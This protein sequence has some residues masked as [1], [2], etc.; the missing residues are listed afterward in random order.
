MSEIR[1]EWAAKA[2]DNLDTCSA[3]A[4]EIEQD[5]QMLPTTEVYTHDATLPF[6]T[7]QKS[8]AVGRTNL[9]PESDEKHDGAGACVPEDVDV[10]VMNPPWGKRI[11]NLSLE[12]SEEGAIVRSLLSQFVRKSHY[13]DHANDT[14]TYQHT[15]IDTGC[16]AGAMTVVGLVR[17]LTLVVPC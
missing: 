10:V 14:V 1:E 16:F 13:R 3:L 5:G 6:S 11:G 7:L 12:H 17:L 4:T 2:R 15:S 8:D 9:Q